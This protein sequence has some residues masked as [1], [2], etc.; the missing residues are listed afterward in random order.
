MVCTRHASSADNRHKEGD[1]V[2]DSENSAKTLRGQAN[3]G[4]LH[5]QK[6]NFQ[7]ETMPR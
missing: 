6:F 7:M 1:R 4:Y 3:H 2:A 5:F